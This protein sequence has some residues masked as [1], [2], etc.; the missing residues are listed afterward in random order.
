MILGQPLGDPGF[1][2]HSGALAMSSFDLGF[3]NGHASSSAAPSSVATYSLADK[4]PSSPQLC[5]K[6]GEP[7]YLKD[8][9]RVR[10]ISVGSH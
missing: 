7:W 2:E 10:G 6:A 1:R 4:L 3:P 8:C 9:A 5:G